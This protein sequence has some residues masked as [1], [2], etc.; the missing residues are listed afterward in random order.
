MSWAELCCL[1]CTC[2]QLL[3]PR[4]VLRKWLNISTK[5]SDFSADTDNDDFTDDENDNNSNFDAQTFVDSDVD[6]Q[7]IFYSLLYFYLCFWKGYLIL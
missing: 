4:V 2:L 1:G 7:G 6:A 3:W 5:D